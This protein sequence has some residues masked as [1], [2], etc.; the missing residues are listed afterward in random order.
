[1]DLNP[2]TVPD[3][4]IAYAII[5]MDFQPLRKPE[6]QY[7]DFKEHIEALRALRGGR[8]PP[9]VPRRPPDH[10]YEE[11]K[12]EQKHVPPEATLPEPE[13][14]VATLPPYVGDVAMASLMA[15]RGQIATRLLRQETHKMFLNSSSSNE[16]PTV[17][18]PKDK[19]APNP[20]PPPPRD[21]SRERRHRSPPPPAPKY[22]PPQ[23][24][25]DEAHP[26]K[27]A[28]PPEDIRPKEVPAASLP[29]DTRP[30]EVSC[31]G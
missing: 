17:E 24:P 28:S 22:P 9:R 6:E 19:V 8:L 26:P 25:R 10:A 5:H 7:W 12:E 2:L 18:V 27:E 31:C 20:P 15:M 23:S 21:K 30:K 14:E 29:E 1:M 3:W 13:E 4:A 11:F 16:T